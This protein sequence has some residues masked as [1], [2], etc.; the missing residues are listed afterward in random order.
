M[1]EPTLVL[2]LKLYAL[3]NQG[4]GTLNAFQ[5]AIRKVMQRSKP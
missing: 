5:S 4:K 1:S 2:D 3:V